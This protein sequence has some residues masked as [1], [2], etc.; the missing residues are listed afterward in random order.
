MTRNNL[1]C[2]LL[3]LLLFSFNHAATAQTGGTITLLDKDSNKCSFDIPGP[4][5]GVTQQFNLTAYGSSMQCT[6]WKVRSLV[7]TDLPSAATIYMTDHEWCERGKGKH[8]ISLRTV[9]NSTSTDP[10]AP[11]E[12]ANLYAFAEKSI[13]TPGLQLVSKRQDQ[14]ADPKDSVKCIEVTT[15]AGID[16]PPLAATT[17]IE[18]TEDKISD[19][20]DSVFN[21]PADKAIVARQHSG[22]ER[23]STKYWCVKLKQGDNIATLSDPSQSVSFKESGGYYFTCPPNQVMTGREHDGD[24]NGKTRY[25][26]KTPKVNGHALTV[27][28]EAWSASQSE[29]KSRFDCRPGKVMI[30]RWHEDDEKGKTRVRCATVH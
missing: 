23:K 20:R 27:T 29:H 16:T 26:C 19:E 6:D 22:D 9:K 24:E 4:G 1:A 18:T 21:C 7:L 3:T 11:W 25:S 2:S 14:G 10:S 13:I 30:G 15:S 17:Q 5:S 28:P 12:I 8:Q